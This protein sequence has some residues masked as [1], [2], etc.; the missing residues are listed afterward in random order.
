M[1]NKSS[2]SLDILLQ[3]VKKYVE[4]RLEYYRISS[5]GN[6]A[7]TTSFI[8]YTLAL[9]ILL[10]FSFIIANVWFAVFIA[11]MFNSMLLGFT[12]FIGLYLLAIIV[13]VAFHSRIISFINNRFLSKVLQSIDENEE[14]EE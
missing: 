12:I 5:M 7:S 6:A 4:L 3:D 10:F 2:N 13:L 14:E 8:I 11:Y 1:S 9:L